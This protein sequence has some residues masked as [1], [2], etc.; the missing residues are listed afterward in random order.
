[1]NRAAEEIIIYPQDSDWD[2]GTEIQVD[3]SIGVGKK[4]CSFTPPKDISLNSFNS[5]EY[6]R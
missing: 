4:N 3:V 5:C 6:W 1:M 2:R